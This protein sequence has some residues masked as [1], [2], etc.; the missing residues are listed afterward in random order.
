M[1]HL[2][3]WIDAKLADQRLFP[4]D[5]G[6]PSPPDFI[7]QVKPM[8]QRMFRVY[9]HLFHHHFRQYL[10]LS[11]QSHLYTCFKHFV[12][13]VLEFRLIDARELA[14]L[15]QLIDNLLEREGQGWTGAETQ[16]DAAASP[17]PS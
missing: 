2:S 13:F 17:T 4:V 7:K 10:H 14:P 11:A 9:G 15:Q 8:F 16:A 1:F 5:D 12:L 6:E 3:E